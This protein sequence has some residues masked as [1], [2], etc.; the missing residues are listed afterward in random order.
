MPIKRLGLVIHRGRSDAVKAADVVRAWCAENGI[1][2]HE[3]DVWEDE[4]PRRHSQEEAIAAG[5]PDLIVT[6]GGDGTFLRGARIA[7]CDDSRVLGVDFGHVGFLTEVPSD[8]IR[9]SLEAVHC[10]CAVAEKRMTLTLRTSRAVEIPEGMDSLL[11]HGR[12][13]ALP[14]PTVLGS[15]DSAQEPG[16]AL[17]VVALNDIVLEKLARDRQVDLA[18]YVGGHLLASYSADAVIVATPTGSTA[19]SFAAGGPILSPRLDAL[20][21]TPVAPHMAFNRT[22]VTAADEPVTV[23]ILPHSGPVAISIDGQLRGVL[24]PGDWAE[25]GPADSRL[26]VVRFGEADFYRRVR[27]RF[28]L[29]DAPAAVAD[30]EAPATFRP[31][32]SRPLVVD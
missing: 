13:P 19:Y 28:R 12:G 6:L 24:G 15:D 29:A 2:C 1:P 27:N 25:V 21:F 23:R 16:I 22:V 4:Q 31:T 14:S 5:H 10:D 26:N 32:A 9:A 8:Q 3:I 17:D 30:G 18:L 20:V 7:R 11:R